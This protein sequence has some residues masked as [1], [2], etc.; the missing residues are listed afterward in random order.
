MRF[1]I[2]PPYRTGVTG[3]PEWMASFARHAD[4]LGFES[5]Y[6]VEHAIV[7][8]DYSTKYPY[9]DTGRMP[10]P[11]DCPIPDPLEMLAFLAGQTERLVLATGVVVLP[12]H[13]PV[14]LAKR[15]A[16]IDVVSAGRMRLGIGVGWMR[17]EVEAAGVEFETRGRRTDE[18]IEAMRALWTQEQASFAGEFFEFGPVYSRPQPVQVGGVPIHVGGHSPAAARRAG[19]VGDGFFPLGLDV[20]MLRN[21]LAQMRTAARSVGRDP[22]GIELTM[23]GLLTATDTAA[24]DAASEIGAERMVMSTTESDL[25][26][27]KAQ[28]ATFADAHGLS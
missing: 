22:D 24:V 21:R 25:D 20:E 16:T 1:G 4:D 28:M 15:L 13:T 10:L 26:V 11:E 8:A 14:L 5:I 18:L 9:A 23:G 2:L 3:D 7:G 27:V 6:L 17:E 12:L 19:R